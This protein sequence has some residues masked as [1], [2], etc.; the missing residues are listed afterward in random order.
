M[1]EFP[2]TSLQAT[3]EQILYARVLEK[4]MIIGLLTLVVT[5]TIY[6]FGIMKPYIPLN[7]LS[8][9]WSMDVNAYLHHA[10]IR[11]GWAW[12]SLLSYGDFIN[13]IGVAIL[14]GTTI[15]CY[16]AIVPTLV[17]NRDT[18]YAVLALLEAIILFLAASGIIAGG[19]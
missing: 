1:D 17:K 14:A 15:F 11:N 5:F 10:D 12:L 19:H 3:S 13:F 2:E 7:K 16:L 6:A 18:I 8:H 4:G 9:Y